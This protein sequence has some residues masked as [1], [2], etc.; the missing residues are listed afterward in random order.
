M[1]FVNLFDETGSI[2]LVV[3]PKT[4]SGSKDI[5]QPHKVILLKGKVEAK[6]N[7]LTVVVDK[8]I[9]LNRMKY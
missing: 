3:F 6:D 2:E 8:A 4:Y 5:W 1:A 9:D 7:R